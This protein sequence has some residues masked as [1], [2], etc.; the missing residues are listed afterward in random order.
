V[1]DRQ[2]VIET[3]WGRV[4]DKCVTVALWIIIGMQIGTGWPEFTNIIFPYLFATCVSIFLI[5]QLR[6]TRWFQPSSLS[7]RIFKGLS[8]DRAG[9]MLNVKR[10]N[11]ESDEDYRK[12][13]DE[14]IS[15]R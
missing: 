9:D 7:S 5:R 4:V 2:F 15:V 10:L 3:Y 6:R 14:H 13:I 11:N 1:K 12:R 8:L